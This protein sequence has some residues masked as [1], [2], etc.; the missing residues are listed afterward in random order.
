MKVRTKLDTSKGRVFFCSDLHLGHSNI[1]TLNKDSRSRW[2]TIEEMN[3]F[4]EDNVWG[5]LDYNDTLIDLGD[6]FW[7][8][9]T[10]RLAE[11]LCNCKGDLWKVM[12]NHDAYGLY[13]PPQ[14]PLREYY[15]VLGDV[16]DI[17]ILHEGKEYMLT[18]DHYP[19]VSWN[20]K[21]YGSFMLHG[22]CHGNVDKFNE[23]CPDLRVDVGLDASLCKSLGGSVMLEF[24]QILD[25]FKNKIGGD[26]FR[27]YVKNHRYNL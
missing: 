23:D 8:M 19:K 10:D 5:K 7:K 9:E 26:D 4:L 1:L 13:Y 6:T 25:Y 12:G 14:Q 11:I 16:L 24:S 2:K 27:N 17:N 3:T 20:H 18:L 15:S 21:A 22:H